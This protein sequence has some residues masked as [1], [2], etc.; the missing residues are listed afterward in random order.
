MTRASAAPAPLGEAPSTCASSDWPA[1]GCR[2][3]GIED[4]IRVPSPA[5][6]TTVRLVRAVIRILVVAADVRRRRHKA[7]SARVETGKTPRIQDQG[8]F[9]VNVCRVIRWASGGP[10]TFMARDTDHLA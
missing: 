7:F 1:T 8:A 2:T 10:K 6:S 5:A 3:F 9:P 4:R